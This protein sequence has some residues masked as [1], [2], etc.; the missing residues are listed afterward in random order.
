MFSKK[1]QALED[2]IESVRGDLKVIKSS[3]INYNEIKEI[4]KDTLP[5]PDN[6]VKDIS[7][8][9]LTLLSD[10][11]FIVENF[12]VASEVS[13]ATGKVMDKIS[14]LEETVLSREESI[15]EL[16]QKLVKLENRVDAR[17]NDFYKEFT[18]R[19]FDTLSAFMR[20]NKEISL[21]SAIS[22]GKDVDL[23][24]LKQE[25]MKPMIEEG[26]A[27]KRATEAERINKAIDSKGEKVRK[28]WDK[29]KE[30]RLRLER[31]SR[32]TEFVDA[33]LEILNILMEGVDVSD[34]DKPDNPG[35]SDSRETSGN[36]VE[37]S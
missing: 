6:D 4:V 14:S 35:W 13:K 11:R 22:R 10:V 5:E 19:Y 12:P 16:E 24:K 33:K 27:Q 21:V 23:T 34:T 31:E 3:Q 7:K 2:S 36:S 26:W 1:F 29:Y 28:A 32:S 37:G 9:I 18:D 25:L 8:E 17:L 30:E 20:W 15:D